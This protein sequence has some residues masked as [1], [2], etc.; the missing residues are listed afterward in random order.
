MERHVPV[1][2]HYGGRV[3]FAGQ[4]GKN[5]AVSAGV[6]RQQNLVALNGSQQTTYRSPGFN[7]PA[8]RLDG[9]EI[10]VVADPF[11]TGVLQQGHCAIVID[12]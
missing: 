1:E 9:H 8:R 4:N 6:R 3:L 10:A 2:A 12:S 5:I 11:D 7:L